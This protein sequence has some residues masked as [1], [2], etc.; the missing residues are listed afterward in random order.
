[1]KTSVSGIHPPRILRVFL[2]RVNKLEN[3]E[4]FESLSSSP[5]GCVER[6][7]GRTTQGDSYLVS[8]EKSK[9]PILHPLNRLYSKQ[10]ESVLKHSADALDEARAGEF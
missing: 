8:D 3:L 4:S 5:H 6:G 7:G 10:A 2:V 9:T 1:M